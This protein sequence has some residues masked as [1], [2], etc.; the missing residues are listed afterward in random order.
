MHVR[1]FTDWIDRSVLVGLEVMC[2]TGVLQGSYGCISRGA[3]EISH[4][5]TESLLVSTGLSLSGLDWYD[6]T[7]DCL[8]VCKSTKRQCGAPRD[9]G[10]CFSVSRTYAGALLSLEG[11][12]FNG[13]FVP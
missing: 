3:Y 11:V 9:Q 8:I 7:Y 2:R 12:E 4:A 10:I 1:D 13:W 6:S 5:S